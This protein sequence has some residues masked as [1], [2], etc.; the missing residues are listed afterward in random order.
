MAAIDQAVHGF[1]EDTADPVGEMLKTVRGALIAAGVFSL[2][3]NMAILVMPFYMFSV[4]IQVLPSESMST[5]GWL[6][7]IVVWVLLVQMAV[8]IARSL[9]LAQV[10]RWVDSRIGSQLFAMSIERS[11]PRGSQ[12]DMSLLKGLQNLRTF[13]SSPQVFVIMDAPWVPMFLLVLFMMDYYI[14]LTALVVTLV[15][16]G[17]TLGARLT[18]VRMRREA[19][20]I[21]G[22]A[23]SFAD[24]A[25]RDADTI[26][27]LGMSRRMIRR[28]RQDIDRV[29]DMQSVVSRRAGVFYAFVKMSRV[30][31][32]AAVMTVA[33]VQ[34]LN[35]N[36][37]MAPGVMMAALLLVGRCI[38]PL[39]LL[40]NSYDNIVQAFSTMRGLRRILGSSPGRWIE[41][42]TPAEPLGRLHVLNL[43]Y[44]PETAPRLILNRIT[45][46]LQPGESLG[47]IG[48]TAAGKSSLARLLTG[49]EAP[50]GGD[51]RLDGTMLSAW[52]AAE[53][54]RHIGYL[55]QRVE[56]MAGTVFENVTRFETDA[57]EEDAWKA[58]DLAGVRPVVEALPDGLYSQV[59]EG[60]GFLSGGQRQSLGLARAVY[61]PVKLVILDEPN[62]N[63]DTSGEAALMT[64]VTALKARG[65]TVV[66]IL[67]RPSI[68]HHVDHIMVLQDG[69]IQKM[70]PRDEM[71]PLLRMISD[72]VGERQAQGRQVTAE[73][74]ARQLRAESDT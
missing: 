49:I 38:M 71:L 9:M 54:G 18:T 23:M 69:T 12:A 50:T 25:I 32:L 35:P 30:A 27:A 61:G 40:V 47:I 10:A 7:L 8:D 70:A 52:P 58:V 31:S 42:I 41:N 34:M 62:A 14:G 46:S 19:G 59:G 57:T 65:V 37:G 44:R 68:L 24:M 16:F 29:I 53:R 74:A 17:L 3:V 43:A 55:P 5:L 4:F 26:E 1:G 28:W 36:S 64:A 48:H 2:V 11:I 51:V 22:R 56:L 21:S 66:V 72:N 39:E 73:D 45:F 63:L 15:A 6:A 60:G 33:C 67:H 13:V 20:A